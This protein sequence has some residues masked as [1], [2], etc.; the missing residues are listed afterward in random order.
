MSRSPRILVVTP[1]ITYLPA[2]MGNIANSLRAQGGGLADVSATLIAELY[3]RGADIHVALPHY[4][5]LFN[6]N[7]ESFLNKELRIYKR[8]MSGNR[9]HLAEDRAFYYRDQVYNVYSEQNIEIALKFQREVINNIIQSV[10]PDLVHCNDWMTGLIPAACK[11]LDIPCV[12]T[13]HN[14]HT[15]KRTMAQIEDCGID[16]AE[17]WQ[18][19]YFER[20]P[21]NYEESRETNGVDFLSTGVFASGAINTVSPTFL[22]EILNG[23]H[24]FVSDALRQEICRKYENSQAVGI[25]NSP[26]PEQKSTLDKA[27]A[28]NYGV[29]DHVAG[30]LANKRLLQEIVGLDCEDQAPLFFWPSRL[31]P[32]QK[33]CQLFTDILYKLMAKY[34]EEKLQV[35]IVATGPHQNAFQ[36]IV[37]DHGLSHRI[38]VCNFDK[39]LASLAY[40]ASDFVLM[41]SLYEPCGLPQM[42]CQRYGSLPIVRDTGGLHDTVSHFN[43]HKNTGNGFVFKDYDS[44]GLFW[45][46]DQAMHFYEQQRDVREHHIKRIMTEANDRFNHHVTTSNYTKLYESLLNKPIVNNKESTKFLSLPTSKFNSPNLE[47]PLAGLKKTEK[48]ET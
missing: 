23:Q 40:A 14:I 7:V 13:V 44:N 37:D 38:A 28:R 34:R 47:E 20:Y 1:E 27:L 25:L 21:S 6:I 26:D 12:F 41:P 32:I 17:F 39:K 48:V 5:K 3:S 43:L 42:V 11:R 30:K 4:R 33:G 15:V 35:V 19:L 18:N 16:V 2:H 29:V 24:E 10:E 8:K 22:L 9:I 36:R 46:I 31:D 45:A